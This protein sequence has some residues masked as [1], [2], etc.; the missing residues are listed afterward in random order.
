RELTYAELAERVER[1]A[2][3]LRA[4]GVGRGDRV[5]VCL[6]RGADS[7]VA[8]LAVVRAGGVYLPLD[9]AYPGER[10]EFMVADAGARLVVAD[11][12]TADRV[13]G[14]AAV[15]RLDEEG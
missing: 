15:L 10:L 5:G 9:P 12:R 14:G 1:L 3:G 4:R 6:E 13:P 8:L 11:A 2:A 7:V